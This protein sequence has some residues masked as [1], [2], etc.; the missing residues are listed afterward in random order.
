ML[1]ANAHKL[2]HYGLQIQNW[3]LNQQMFGWHKT[4]VDWEGNEKSSWRTPNLLAEVINYGRPNFEYTTNDQVNNIIA[5]IL[6]VLHNQGNM[7]YYEYITK[8]TESSH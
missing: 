8:D 5:Y 4:F 1:K 3:N 7:Q 6:Q 2:P